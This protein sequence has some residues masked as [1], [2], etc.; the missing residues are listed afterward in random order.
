FKS[1]WF[2]SD[3]SENTEFYVTFKS[4]AMNIIDPDKESD[5]Y[6]KL[7]PTTSDNIN[8]E[9]ASSG[10]GWALTSSGYIVTNFHV[11]ENSREIRIRGINGD[12]SKTFRAVVVIEDKKNDLAIL[13]LEDKYFN[14]LGSIPYV[15][16]N[17]TIE[18][19]SS[20]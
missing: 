13:K 11:V 1:R 19:G 3:K 5:I 9:I 15:V 14:T 10:T 8:R 2:M 16:S 17:K 4:G 7:F 6:I 20:I 18:V 12:F